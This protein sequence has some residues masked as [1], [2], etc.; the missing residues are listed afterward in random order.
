MAARR[1][2]VL[3]ATAAHAAVLV[4]FVYGIQKILNLQDRLS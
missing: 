3:A 1:A 2:E 4:V